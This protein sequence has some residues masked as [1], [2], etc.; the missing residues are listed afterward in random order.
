VTESFYIP[1]GTDAK[2]S[3]ARGRIYAYL[4]KLPTARPFVVMVTEKKPS[5]SNQQNALLW[6]LYEDALEI[7][8]EKL[9]GFDKRDLHELLLIEHFGAEKVTI[10]GRTKLKA[11]KRSSTLSKIEFASFVDFVVRYFAEHGIVLRLPGE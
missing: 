2:R 5:R 11:L 7:G 8:G 9:A 6:A 3:D 10:F 4:T 1:M